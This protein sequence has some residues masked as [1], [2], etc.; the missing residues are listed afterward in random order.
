MAIPCRRLS[1]TTVAQSTPILLG[2]P[3][4]LNSLEMRPMG[5]AKLPWEMIVCM[6]LTVLSTWTLF[7]STPSYL[8]GE[9]PGDY[10]WRHCGSMEGGN[11][12]AD[13]AITQKFLK[14][15]EGFKDQSWFKARSPQSSQKDA[16]D[17]WAT[18]NL[19]HAQSIYSLG[20]QLV[21]WAC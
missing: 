21:S 4:M 12:L 13:D 17:Y 1:S 14:N 9:F 11:A 18:Q 8:T 15:V 5:P 16:S 10:G 20:F 7:C 19:A 6:G 3:K 2:R